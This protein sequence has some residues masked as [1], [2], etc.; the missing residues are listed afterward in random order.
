MG[1]HPDDDH[2]G[3][4]SV[5]TSISS[6]IKSVSQSI[7]RRCWDRAGRGQC[8]ER[9]L[10]ADT[11]LMRPRRQYARSDHRAD[12]GQLT[13][14]W[15]DIFDG[16]IER[17]AIVDQLGIEGDDTRGQPASLMPAGTNNG[18][19]AA[20]TPSCDNLELPVRQG[21]TRID[22]KVDGAQQRRQ[23]VD[24]RMRSVT[25]CSRATTSTRSTTRWPRLG[26]PQPRG[27]DRQHRARDTD[28]VRRI[29]LADPR[30]AEAG[31]SD[32]SATSTPASVTR[33]A[34]P[35]P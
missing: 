22:P 24:S 15:S 31:I 21:L 10:R 16:G 26:P 33:W 9:R 20:V 6:T 28:R 18:V 12:P 23:S 29:S 17:L 4:C 1:A 2:G 13:Q 11:T 32:G 14:F 7:S 8:G 30:R 34:S 3:Q 25:I 35:A 19:L 5:E 27:V